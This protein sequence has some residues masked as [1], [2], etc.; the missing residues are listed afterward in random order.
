MPKSRFSCYY[1]GMQLSKYFTLEELTTTSH[2]VDNTPDV[3]AEDSLRRLA[4]LLDMIYDQIGP[5]RITSGYRSPALNEEIGGAT[6]SYHMRGLAADILPYNDTPYN[7]FLK[8][9]QSPLLSSIGELINEADEK[10][11]V[12]VSLPTAEKQSVVMYLQGGSYL[13]YSPSDIAAMKSG[14]DPSQSDSSVDTENVYGTED[15][16][17]TSTMIMVGAAAVI[18]TLVVLSTMQSRRIA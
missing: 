12:H 5:F 10:G 7:F 14:E 4:V 6:N 2:A 13:R 18:V 16:L 15:Q 11:V 8:I 1:I 17:N 9:V 3:M